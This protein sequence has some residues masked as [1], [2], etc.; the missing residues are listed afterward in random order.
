MLEGL[1]DG[2][3]ERRPITSWIFPLFVFSLIAVSRPTALLATDLAPGGAVVLSE[4]QYNPAP[5]LGPDGEYEYVEVHNRGDDAVD[6]TGWR[7]MDRD[8]SK[9]FHIPA[10]TSIAPGGYLVIAGD[11]AALRTL[12][13]EGVA[14]VGNL[15]FRLGNGG[16]TVRLVGAEG[17]LVD[18][19]EY[20][21]QLPWP[22]EAD[23]EGPSLE[24]VSL[25]NDITDFTNFHP[26]APGG[27][28]GTPNSRA[29][30]IPGRQGIP[31]R[32]EVVFNEIMYHPVKDPDAESKQHC[33]A[34]EFLELY[35]RGSELVDVSRWRIM[36][37]VDFVFPAETVI[38]PEGFLVVY[39][40]E[41]GFRELH[42]AVTNATGTNAMGPYA[43]RLDDGGEAL[44]LVDAAGSP[45]DYVE[46]DDNP[47][48]PVSADGIQGSLELID[49]PRP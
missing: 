28:P 38:A 39:S 43:R 26:S 32:H 18:R 25:A 20:D 41:T 10:R 9:A 30:D 1:V 22:Q 33:E 47:S 16:D 7:F 14:I 42:G 24:R 15:D 5:D 17:Q 6:L 11:A 4:I 23:G 2:P 44:L 48:W 40:D 21:D 35:N 49:A 19:V 37:G 34:H 12:V 36:G 29:G 13:G 27:T 46:Y 8:S 45:V 3:G 31:I